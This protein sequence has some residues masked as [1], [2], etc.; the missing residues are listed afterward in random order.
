MVPAR[1]R[2]AVV[3]VEGAAGG[4][5][6]GTT[7]R[8]PASG[9]LG[10]GVTATVELTPGQIVTLSV[11]G[12]GTDASK[13]GMGGWPDGGAGGD[14]S[15]PAIGGGPGGGGGGLSSFAVGGTTMLV[16]GGGGGGGGYGAPAATV[17][18]GAGGAGDM[19]GLAGDS[20][21]AGVLFS[22]GGGGK[23]GVTSGPGAGPG[24][25]GTLGT[26]PSDSDT[27]GG[28]GIPGTAG[29]DGSGSS[30]GTGGGGYGSSGGG[31]GGGYYGG[32]GGGAGQPAATCGSGGGGG[33]G[34]SSFAGPGLSAT[35]LNGVRSGDGQVTIRY[36]SRPPT[37]R[38]LGMRLSPDSF[39]AARKGP[40][41]T[42]TPGIGTSI[43]YR[44]TLAGHTTFRV[45]RCRIVRG[46]C[47]G[48]VLIGSFT[49]HDRA[50]ANELRFSGRLYGRALKAGH[51]VLQATATL[52]G[53]VSARMTTTFQIL[54]PCACND[55]DHDGDCDTAGPV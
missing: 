37:P 26:V 24:A 2:S 51:Y 11:G 3:T 17:L 16:A 9:G 7:G 54:P 53:Q 27:C 6:A 32:G 29:G 21:V 31:G 40:T 8:T 33:G 22:G 52:A 46:H 41:L 38:L 45:L 36:A 12:A 19:P 48:L 25:G 35:F 18:G 47:T 39:R 28:I 43:G 50:G 30:G 20:I 4:R 13:G 14:Q 42:T 49:H 44:D 1:V 55:R 15:T 10:S 34:G 23:P 5:G